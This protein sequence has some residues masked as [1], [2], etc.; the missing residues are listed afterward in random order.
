MH[1]KRGRRQEFS[2]EEEE[3]PTNRSKRGKSAGATSRSVNEDTYLQRHLA[4]RY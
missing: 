4:N 3:A 2:E 1:S